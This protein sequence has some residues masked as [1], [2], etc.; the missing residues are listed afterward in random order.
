MQL[1]YAQ[2]F[3]VTPYLFR[4]AARQGGVNSIANIVA[5]DPISSLFVN[6][7]QLPMGAPGRSGQFWMRRRDVA[8]SL[9]QDSQM[10]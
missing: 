6:H 1:Q 8:A 9:P 2:R 3:Q 5:D 10:F 4:T 7:A